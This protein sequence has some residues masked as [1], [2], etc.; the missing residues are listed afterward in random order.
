MLSLRFLSFAFGHMWLSVFFAL[1]IFGTASGDESGGGGSVSDATESRVYWSEGKKYARGAWETTKIINRDKKIK[2]DV[3]EKMHI[4][5]CRKVKPESV[6]CS[7]KRDAQ[8]EMHRD[9]KK[10][11]MD[12]IHLM[13]EKWCSFTRAHMMSEHC[14]RFEKDPTHRNYHGMRGTTVDNSAPV[15]R[16]PASVKKKKL[17]FGLP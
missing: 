6:L 16:A 3:D 5:F 17:A 11:K 2:R 8:L 4:W 7:G 12:D 1:V 10:T 13:Y 15:R 14:K 9:E